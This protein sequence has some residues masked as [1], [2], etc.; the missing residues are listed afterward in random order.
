VTRGLSAGSI[1]VP[2]VCT[3]KPCIRGLRFPVAWLLG[4]LTAG[5]TREKI[6]V[7]YLYLEA[8]DTDAA[9]RYAA[10]LPEDETVAAPAFGRSQSAISLISTGRRAKRQP[11]F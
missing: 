5:E 2:T 11:S 9:L 1:R 3:A 8:G 6:L 4:L 7:D 10:L